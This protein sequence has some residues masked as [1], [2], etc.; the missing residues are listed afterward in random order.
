MGFFTELANYSH[1]FKRSL[2]LL[3]TAVYEAGRKEDL[4]KGLPPGGIC[5]TAFLKTKEGVLLA[6]AKLV[7][8]ADIDTGKL[9]TTLATILL[10][11][12]GKEKLKAPERVKIVED[13]EKGT[14]QVEIPKENDMLFPYADENYTMPDIQEVVIEN[15][16]GN[17]RK[18]GYEL[19]VAS[20]DTV[21]RDFGETCISEYYT[22]F[23]SKEVPDVSHWSQYEDP[24]VD[25]LPK[26][27]AETSRA[28]EFG[29]D[30]H[31]NIEKIALRVFEPDEYYAGEVQGTEHVYDVDGYDMKRKKEDEYGLSDT[32]E[33]AG[34]HEIEEWH[35][36]DPA[37]EARLSCET[38]H[39]RVFITDGAFTAFS[40]TSVETEEQKTTVSLNVRTGIITVAS[41]DVQNERGQMV[42]DRE[43][44]RKAAEVIGNEASRFNKDGEVK[45]KSIG[46]V[47]SY[48]FAGHELEALRNIAAEM[49]TVIS[50]P[51]TIE[52]YEAV[53]SRNERLTKSIQTFAKDH[54]FGAMKDVFPPMQETEAPQT[55]KEAV[56]YYNMY[57]LSSADTGDVYA[58]YTSTDE[59]LDKVIMDGESPVVVGMSQESGTI[60]ICADMGD[61]RTAHVMK[62]MGIVTE[63][64]FGKDMER[65]TEEAH[66]Y[67]F[68]TITIKGR[69]ATIFSHSVLIAERLL[70]PGE[71]DDGDEKIKRIEKEVAKIK[72]IRE[73][74]EK[75]AAA[76]EESMRI[77]E[78][79]TPETGAL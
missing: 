69:G 37:A 17:V 68:S 2:E 73:S 53:K 54:G 65:G 18:S 72:E 58:Y 75:T 5:E 31:G 64:L 60:K 25:K 70:H 66:G 38:D 40:N 3:G 23:G 52:D 19:Y 20:P 55:V 15:Y 67:E 24:G 4:F 61:E 39:I 36:T 8:L 74:P 33:A 14:K 46:G 41:P 63:S 62:N 28:V 13:Q 32:P 10:T 59:M 76:M 45:V 42:R 35:K 49:E 47:A 77:P 7:K 12:E 56:D 11:P 22:S 78:N 1:E 16:E 79:N 21:E 57:P 43:G 29:Y 51:E 6:V 9:R 30:E 48:R 34:L 26:D 27:V 44:G 50:P 71:P